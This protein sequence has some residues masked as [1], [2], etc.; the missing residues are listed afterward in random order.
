MGAQGSQRRGRIS[1]FFWLRVDVLCRTSVNNQA[2]F[3]AKRA[4]T[5][6]VLPGC[7]ISRFKEGFNPGGAGMEDCMRALC[8]E[9]LPSLRPV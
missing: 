2:V 6:L 9:T 7:G 8:C 4:S 5:S 3:P 1:A